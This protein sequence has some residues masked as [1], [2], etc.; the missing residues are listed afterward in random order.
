MAGKI[1]DQK[2]H[3]LA[4]PPS[5]GEHPGRLWLETFLQFIAKNPEAT[6]PVPVSHLAREER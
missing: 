2:P 6:L 3:R 5:R 4:D 1:N